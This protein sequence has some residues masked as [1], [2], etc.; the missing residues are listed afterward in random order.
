MNT[1]ASSPSVF[2]DFRGASVN[3][4]R[5]SLLLALP[6]IFALAEEVIGG[7]LMILDTLLHD[8]GLRILFLLPITLKSQSSSIQD[9]FLGITE[10]VI[11]WVESPVVVSVTLLAWSEVHVSLHVESVRVLVDLSTSSWEDHVLGTFESSCRKTE[12][13]LTAGSLLW[14]IVLAGKALA[15]GLS[16]M[17]GVLAFFDV[18]ELVS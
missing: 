18:V 7:I 9:L 4:V 15:E 11:T 6:E 2:L 1:L 16:D 12:L 14:P 13:S 5:I 3:E 10:S 17:G 8:D